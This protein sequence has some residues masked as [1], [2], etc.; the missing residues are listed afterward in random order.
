M[1]KLTSAESNFVQTDRVGSVRSGGSGGL[2]YQAQYPY[3]VE[4]AQQTVNNREKYATYTRDTATGLDYAM[5]R[6]YASQWGRFLSPDPYMAN[7]GGPGDPANPQSWNRYAYVQNDPI[8]ASDAKGLWLCYVGVGE[9]GIEP[10]DCENA[11]MP[12]DPG[13][14]PGPGASGGGS[15][16]SKFPNCNPSG[17]STTEKSLT[18][19]PPTTRPPT[20]R[21]TPSSQP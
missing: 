20:R 13:P 2:G 6:Y 11:P 5:N 12:G 1:G 19:S 16:Q 10:T 15:V 14:D 21:P 4:Y 7:N 17:N 18:T 9:G 3:G 8:N